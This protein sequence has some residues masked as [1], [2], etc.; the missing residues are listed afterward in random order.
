MVDGNVQSIKLSDTSLIRALS[1][2]QPG[3]FCEIFGYI[4]ICS[5]HNLRIDI[6]CIQ[7]AVLDFKPEIRDWAIG[8]HIQNL[9]IN[10]DIDFSTVL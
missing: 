8:S 7:V 6:S 3:G 10:M 2:A 5:D 9:E 1:T 4:A